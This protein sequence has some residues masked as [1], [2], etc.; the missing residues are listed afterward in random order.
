[1][2]GVFQA[3]SLAFFAC[4]D[5]SSRCP[6]AALLCQGCFARAVLLRLLRPHVNPAHRVGKPT[7]DMSRSLVKHGAPPPPCP[8]RST[9]SRSRECSEP[10]RRRARRRCGVPGRGEGGASREPLRARAP[11]PSAAAS[12]APPR[13]HRPRRP[14]PYRSPLRRA[15][16]AEL[17]AA[18]AHLRR[19]G[20]PA[21]G[22]LRGPGGDQRAA[23]EDVRG[24]SIRPPIRSAPPPAPR[25]RRG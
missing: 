21:R 18:G 24:P 25:P 5:F 17:G 9:P 14:A 16:L 11:R 13:P 10:E 4:C 23:R 7:H 6:A 22:G 12:P 20:R 19:A 3:P 15:T 1:M 8:A 2:R